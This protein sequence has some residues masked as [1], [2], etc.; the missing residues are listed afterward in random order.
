[1]CGWKTWYVLFMVGLLFLVES[2]LSAGVFWSSW[3]VPGSSVFALLRSSWLSGRIC[4]RASW[5][6]RL[7]FPLWNC[8]TDIVFHCQKW[9]PNLLK[10]VSETNVLKICMNIKQASFKMLMVSFNFIY[11]P[12]NIQ[13]MR[14]NL[15]RINDKPTWNPQNMYLFDWPLQVGYKSKFRAL[16]KNDFLIILCPLIVSVL[17]GPV[18]M[19]H[20]N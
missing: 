1:M 8:R 5:D 20:A 7:Y 11:C 2:A 6:G 13:I 16:D 14:H 10:A 9:F 17:I 12:R 18:C 4:A 19:T 15:L 3:A